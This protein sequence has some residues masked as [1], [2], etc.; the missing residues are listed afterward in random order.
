MPLVLHRL[1]TFGESVA[2]YLW[3]SDPIIARFVGPFDVG[4]LA[5]SLLFR[6]GCAGASCAFSVCG[7]VST[8]SVDLLVST[9]E[10]FVVSSFSASGAFLFNIFRYEIVLVFGNNF[11]R[12]Y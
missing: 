1:K 12:L 5:G 10:A 2:S 9:A 8:C 11:C 4:F 3:L 6:A 7:L